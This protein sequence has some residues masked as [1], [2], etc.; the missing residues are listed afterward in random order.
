MSLPSQEDIEY[1]RQRVAAFTPQC[2]SRFAQFRDGMPLRFLDLAAL[3]RA[4]LIA[5]VGDEFWALP[6]MLEAFEERFGPALRKEH[7]V[8]GLVW[9]AH[10]DKATIFATIPGALHFSQAREADEARAAR[11]ADKAARVVA[12][13]AARVAGVHPGNGRAVKAQEVGPSA[14]PVR[15]DGAG[16]PG[17]R[18]FR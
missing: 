14:A 18:W 13:P 1:A 15:R 4:G 12:V 16:V 6:G 3:E 10:A 11:E 2:R 7:S 8:R 9:N 17:W 5:L